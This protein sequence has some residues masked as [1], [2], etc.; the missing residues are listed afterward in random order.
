MTQGTAPLLD[1]GLMMRYESALRGQTVP[2]DEWRK[3]PLADGERAHML[4]K[5]GLDLPI[6]GE[7]WWGWHD[8]A[9]GD[10]RR[11]L[12][13][14]YQ[15]CLSLEGAVAQFRQSRSIAERIAAD[16]P[17]PL[18]DP[19]RA[20]DPAWLPIKGEGHPVVIDC[21]VGPGQPSPVRF[22]DWQNVDGFR[23]PQ[24]LSLGRM[25]LW[26]IEALESG[27]WRWDN[28][29]TAWRVEEDLLDPNFRATDLT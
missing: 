4:A 3:P 6:E 8:G 1:A 15:E 20:W 29:E 14:P 22:I 17:P 2:V 12:F 27:A 16:S 9:I 21:S 11:K 19:D 7:V 10:G 24:A 26:W 25:I 23:I 28:N 13:G 5:L 18:D